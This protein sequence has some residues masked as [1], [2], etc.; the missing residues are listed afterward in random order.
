MKI[1][2]IQNTLIIMIIGIIMMTLSNIDFLPWWVFLL[3]VLILGIIISL[4][5]LNLKVFILGFIA[6][7]VI[8]FGGNLFFDIKYNGFVLA[9]LANVLSVPKLLLP[10]VSGIIGGVITG[11]AMYVG[12]NVLKYTELTNVD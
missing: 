4:L 12:K 2:L 9:K 5:K 11:L 3:P 1:N 8:W 6:G 10:L 7:F